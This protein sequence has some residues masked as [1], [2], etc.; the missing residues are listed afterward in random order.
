LAILKFNQAK[1]KGCQLCIQACPL[2]LLKQSDKMN[3][4]GQLP[5]MIEEQEK[6]IGCASCAKTCPD[7][8]ISIYED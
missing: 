4:L 6:C 7:C 5:V 1:C 3:A 2:G 8:V